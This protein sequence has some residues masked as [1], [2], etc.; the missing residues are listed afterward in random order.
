[1]RANNI[2]AAYTSLWYREYPRRTASHSR[3]AGQLVPRFDRS[4]FAPPCAGFFGSSRSPARGSRDRF[5]R[6]L[7][8]SSAGPTSPFT[9]LREQ[10]TAF[11]RSNFT[12]CRARKAWK[13]GGGDS[14]R[15]SR[16]FILFHEGRKLTVHD[17]SELVGVVEQ[18]VRHMVCEI[19]EIG[20]QHFH[21]GAAFSQRMAVPEFQANPQS[22]AS[23]RLRNLW[24][25]DRNIIKRLP[26][27]T[28]DLSYSLII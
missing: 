19:V 25:V 20:A 12:A 18:P 7:P 6:A 16:P 1:M 5:R 11:S 4:C 15:P 17:A 24:R 28:E 2:N 10:T 21:K 9:F 3:C 8:P 14:Q 13:G 22:D 26:R 27:A 23:D